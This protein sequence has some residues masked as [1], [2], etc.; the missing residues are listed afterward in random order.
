MNSVSSLLIFDDVW[1]DAADERPL[2]EVNH[3][4]DVIRIF[5]HKRQ[6]G[7]IQTAEANEKRGISEEKMS[8]LTK[9]RG[10]N[11]NKKKVK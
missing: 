1:E 8:V 10:R 2:R 4:V 5:V 11:D 6:I 3:S 7:E 9:N